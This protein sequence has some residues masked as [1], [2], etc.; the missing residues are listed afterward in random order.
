MKKSTFIG[1][2][3]AWVAIA[4]VCIA[5]LAWYHTTDAAVVEAALEGSALVS[6][7]VLLASPVLLFAMGAVIGLLLVWFKD[8]LMGRL[9]KRACLAASVVALALFVLAA[10]PVF[11]PSAGGA[12]LGISV[13]VVYVARL[14]PIL[15]M[16]FGFLYALGC[17]G[18]DASKRGPFDKYLPKDDNADNAEKN[19]NA[20]KDDKDGRAA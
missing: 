2:F 9:A 5:F 4:A 17:A 15:V 18:V 3:V 20:E 7:G 1:N 19:D 13:V 14:A 11:A 12:F 6:L 8:I 10:V 16:L